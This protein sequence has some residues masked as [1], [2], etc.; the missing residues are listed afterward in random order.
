MIFCISNERLSTP[1]VIN[2]PVLVFSRKGSSKFV[3]K[4]DKRCKEYIK[5]KKDNKQLLKEIKQKKKTEQLLKNKI[6]SLKKELQ[7][8]TKGK[9]KM[10]AHSIAIYSL[11][12][13]RTVFWRDI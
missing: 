11:T 8:L 4:Y 12:R 10:G 13:D 5:W 3:R 7:T 9:T 6:A 1:S 2:I